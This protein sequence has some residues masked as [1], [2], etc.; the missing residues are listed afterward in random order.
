MISKKVC[1]HCHTHCRSRDFAWD[2]RDDNRWA[3]GYVVC[4]YLG[5]YCN[6][7]D[8]PHSRCPY[9]FEHAVAE[10]VSE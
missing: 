1:T 6:I 4:F 9:L 8:E 10:V 7:S 3:A 2:Y 5:D